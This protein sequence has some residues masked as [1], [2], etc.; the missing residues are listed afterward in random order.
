MTNINKYCKKNYE[1]PGKLNL[2]QPKSTRAVLTVLAAQSAFTYTDNTPTS[3]TSEVLN[4]D[5][6]DK[7]H[8]LYEIIFQTDLLL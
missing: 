6:I 3:K 2:A 8:Q 7:Y 5:F 1:Y 4:K